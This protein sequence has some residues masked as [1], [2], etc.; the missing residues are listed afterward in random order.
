MD[1]FKDIDSYIELKMKLDMLGVDYPPK[2]LFDFVITEKKNMEKHG[3]Q[4]A[5]WSR[6]CEAMQWRVENGIPLSKMNNL[7][8]GLM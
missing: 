7:N 2:Y 8:T 4:S 1:Q 5:T 6:F 3:L